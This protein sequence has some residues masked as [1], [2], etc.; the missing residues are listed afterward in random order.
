M[1]DTAACPP[2]TSP[3]TI[4]CNSGACACEIG[5]LFHSALI[6]VAQFTPGPPIS[7]TL[8]S[9]ANANVMSADGEV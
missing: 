3:A 2:C 9:H 5:V 1:A 4:V 6:D 8:G 7:Q